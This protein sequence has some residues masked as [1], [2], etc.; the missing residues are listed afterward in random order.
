[1]MNLKSSPS[2]RNKT[3]PLYTV[4]LHFANL[5]L[6][7]RSFLSNPMTSVRNPPQLLLP[8]Q[9]MLQSAYEKGSSI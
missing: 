4:G 5:F 3:P 8:V 2:T 1:M 6:T 7:V 9:S